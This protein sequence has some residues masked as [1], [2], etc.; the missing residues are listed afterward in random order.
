VDYRNSWPTQ[1][2]RP[3]SGACGTGGG[4]ETSPLEGCC[5]SNHRKQSGRTKLGAGEHRLAA[6]WE[7]I[8]NNSDSDKINDSASLK[9]QNAGK[10]QAG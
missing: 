1:H 3:P 2:L 6:I 4:G 7:L 9:Y 10:S 5:N 8:E